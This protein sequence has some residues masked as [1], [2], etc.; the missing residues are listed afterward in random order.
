[1][2]IKP[3]KYQQKSKL[4]LSLANLNISPYVDYHESNYQRIEKTGWKERNY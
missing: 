4:I 3:Y 1:M 2:N